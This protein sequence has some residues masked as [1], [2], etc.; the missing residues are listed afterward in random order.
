MGVNMTN[1]TYFS[2]NTV[3]PTVQ[4]YIT[5]MITIII[6]II[7]YWNFLTGRWEL[8]LACL[9][10]HSPQPLTIGLVSLH[11]CKQG[12]IFKWQTYFKVAL[13][14]SRCNTLGY[15]R[16]T[17]L[18][19]KTDADLGGWLAIF[20]SNLQHLGVIHQCRFPWLC[21][22]TIRWSQRTVCCH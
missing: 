16:Y 17:P 1:T 7:L 20:I 4:Y 5:A 18:Y 2:L 6:I 11:V 3:V 12:N 22:R 10:K 9:E 13:N 15:N 14:A 8:T 19:L 21:P